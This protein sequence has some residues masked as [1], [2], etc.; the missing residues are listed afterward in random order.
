MS[1]AQIAH[2]LKE[3]TQL[4]LDEVEG[5]DIIS[6]RVLS[7][8]VL[9]T[10]RTYQAKLVV[11]IE[12]SASDLLDGF[13]QKIVNQIFDTA[14][15]WRTI[16]HERFI[17]PRGCRFCF[18]RGRETI[19]VIEQDPQVR[20][21]TIM[22]GM[23]QNHDPNLEKIMASDRVLLSIPYSIFVFR[24]TDERL[25]ATKCFWRTTPLKTFQD[26]LCS[27]VLPNIQVG[28]QICMP[29]GGDGDITKV[30]EE[31]ISIFWNSQFNCDLA[32]EWWSKNRISEKIAT[33]DVW[34]DNTLQD[35]LFILKV[36]FRVYKTLNEA[37]DLMAVGTEDLSEVEFKHN[38]A[39]SVDNC[40]E[41]LFHKISS[42][43]K[44]TKFEKHVSKN[45]DDLLK[46]YLKKS[47][48]E[49]ADILA[50]LSH[51]INALKMSIKTERPVV[52]S[53]KF[54]DDIKEE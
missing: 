25:M 13:K 1:V 46:D 19:V 37:V 44:R 28:G 18:K 42:Y 29:L 31:I 54:W 6:E 26:M 24:F 20:T 41:G 4:S 21:L 39:A 9:E 3:A 8:V 49:F 10:I 36:P 51:E 48:A 50:V 52:P 47:T 2:S 16:R 53:G 12:D 40:V 32:S 27:A 38:I 34:R 11:G 43:V 33:G 17:F 7:Q 5:F 35:P 22:R 45:V 23:M 15:G 14:S 30:C